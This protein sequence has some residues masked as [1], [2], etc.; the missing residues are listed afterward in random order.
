MLLTEKMG[1]LKKLSDDI[2]DIESSND[3]EN[4]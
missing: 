4:E 1:V 3:D 2:M